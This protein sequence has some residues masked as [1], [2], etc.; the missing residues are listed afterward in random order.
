MRLDH[1]RVAH[2]PAGRVAEPPRLRIAGRQRP[3]VR[4]D[5][6]HAGIAL[7]EHHDHVRRLDDLPRLRVEC[8]A[9]CCRAA[10]SARR[11]C[12]SR[13]RR[14]ASSSAPRPRLI[15]QT[16]GHDRARSKNAAM[17]GAGGRLFSADLD[18]GAPPVPLTLSLAVAPSRQPG[19]SQIPDRSGWPSKNF[20][21]GA[22]TLTF[23]SGVL[24]APGSGYLG[25]CADSDAR[26]AQ[27]RIMAP[28]SANR[29]FIGQICIG[30][31]GSGLA[32][33]GAWTAG[34]RAS[35]YRPA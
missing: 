27:D 22:L 2:P 13:S 35:G 28:A 31:R 25:H 24:G 1:Q 33:S 15:R 17:L 4:E 6:P 26:H 16:A 32:V 34:A 5:L 18:P 7:V 19:F 11:G 8:A 21:A 29:V 14:S 10:G 20:G 30:T 9:A 3:A 23:P 12:P